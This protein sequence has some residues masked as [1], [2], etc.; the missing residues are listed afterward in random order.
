MTTK[1]YKSGKGK[2][3]KRMTRLNL[4]RNS[5]AATINDK[6]VKN[7]LAFRTPGSMKQGS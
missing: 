3:A 5:H 1:P 7:P 2:L 4:R 6:S